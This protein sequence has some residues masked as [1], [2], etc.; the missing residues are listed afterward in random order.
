MTPQQVIAIRPMT[1]REDALL[2]AHNDCFCEPAERAFF[3]TDDGFT[4]YYMVYANGTV[5][6]SYCNG[7]FNDYE[8]VKKILDAEWSERY[9][10]SHPEALRRYAENHPE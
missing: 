1:I 10:R 5:K 9:T 2:Q 8:R 6:Q 7:S 3:H 4:S